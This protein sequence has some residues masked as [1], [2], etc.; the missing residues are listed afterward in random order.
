MIYFA[1]PDVKAKSSDNEIVDTDNK[2]ALS[3][4]NSP[5]ENDVPNNPSIVGVQSESENVQNSSN[6]TNEMT[7][8][9]TGD[10]TIELLRS[11][12]PEIIITP[13][14][15]DV[16]GPNRPTL[17]EKEVAE[18]TDITPPTQEVTNATPSEDKAS[19]SSQGSDTPPEQVPPHSQTNLDS[20]ASLIETPEDQNNAGKPAGGSRPTSADQTK[21]KTPEPDS[22]ENDTEKVLEISKDG[23]SDSESKLIDDSSSEKPAGILELV[24]KRSIYEETHPPPSD[25][26]LETAYDQDTFE[27]PTSPVSDTME[28]ESDALPNKTSSPATPPADEV[29]SVTSDEHAGAEDPHKDGYDA[30]VSGNEEESNDPSAYIPTALENSMLGGSHQT[31]LSAAADTATV[32]SDV[33][34]TSSETLVASNPPTPES[35]RRPA[36]SVTFSEE[37]NIH[38]NNDDDGKKSEDLRRLM[39]TPTPGVVKV[40]DLE[41]AGLEKEQQPEESQ[42][43]RQESGFGSGGNDDAMMATIFAVVVLL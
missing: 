41:E 10:S 29:T 33:A 6:P 31:E 40:V 11:K 5:E 1:G 4:K 36:K 2:D 16:P 27:K 14:D 43:S 38:N 30:S 15:D 12:T 26:V 18:T 17:Q 39:D 25:V 23:G 21:S 42:A 19:E 37:N 7:E 13:S 34:A 8:I 35:R 24:T 22:P 20:E 32:H 28:S 3:D 9:T